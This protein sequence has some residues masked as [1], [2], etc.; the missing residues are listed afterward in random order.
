MQRSQIRP[1]RINKIFITHAHGDHSFGL[2][3][4]LCLMGME[5][6]GEGGREGGRAFLREKRW[7]ETD[8]ACFPHTHRSNMTMPP[9]RSTDRRAYACSY[10]TSLPPSLPSIPPSLTQAHTRL[11]SFPPSL[12][13]SGPS[14]ATRSLGSCPSTAFMRFAASLAT[15]RSKAEG[16]KRGREGSSICTFPTK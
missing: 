11:L 7:L 4:M 2:P 16:R 6:V 14:S 3:G 1:S 8:T 5:K 10:G 15:T 12:P 13:P 9:W